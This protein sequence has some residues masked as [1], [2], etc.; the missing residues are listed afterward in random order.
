MSA[1]VSARSLAMLAAALLAA[2]PL[3]A[4]QGA[5][6]GPELTAEA[7]DAVLALYNRATTVRLHGES[8]L[9]AGTELA[10]DLGVLDGPLVIAG[11]VRGSVVVINGD[12]RLEPG[13]EIG[14]DVIVVGGIAHGLADA[15]VHGTAIVYRE[16]LRYRREGDLLVQAPLPEKASGLSA[17]H[18]FRFGR[19]DLT[20]A[21]RGAYNR[22]E[23]LPIAGGARIELG[24]SNPTLFEA[25]GIY[26]TESGLRVRDR[27]LGYALR[28]EQHVGGRRAVRLGLAL[29]SEVVPIEAHGLSDR[30]S[31]LAAFVLHRDFRDYYE[32]S[33]RAA[34][35]RIAPRGKPLNAVLELRDETHT[36]M[37][38]GK[39]WSLFDNGR[40]W[41]AQPVVAEGGLTSIAAAVT[42]D[43]RNEV[44]EPSAGWYITA[45][46]E[47]GI[48]GD[49][50][51][52]V[53]MDSATGQPVLARRA[54]DH[55]FHTALFDVRRYART[56]PGSRLAIRTLVAGSLDGGPLPPQRQHAL[57]GEGSLPGYRP[58]QFDCGARRSRLGIVEDD[59]LVETAFYPYY[60]C[61]RIAL[62]QLEYQ[63]RLPLPHDLG[64]RVSGVD[65][66]P[67]P[68]WVIFFDAGR[69]WNEAD[70]R[71]GRGAG[72]D[73]FSADAG[74]GLR[75]GRLGLYWAV[76]L[77]GGS[78]GM[79]FFVRV[80]PRL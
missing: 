41:R 33:G 2:A 18:D 66:G 62:I 59:I 80:G 7:A 65:L 11:R 10:G 36:S 20:L 17:G 69:A 5:D 3:A 24:R 39:P 46:I 56:G 6:A 70:A 75:L 21:V 13:A 45:E 67:P 77:S 1:H 16:P 29:R 27:D 8:I 55:R 40:E 49:L 74:F 32:R 53:A 42:Y 43:T 52:R 31:S 51:S 50:V 61:D 9:P 37:P 12:L 60:G 15:R 38:A 78:E 79:N 14:G 63:V 19:T 73:D 4:Q 34:Y 48:G 68:S 71:N 22:V 35:L 23:G 25:V 47:S 30:E 44:L 58:F 28:V 26:R 57:G 64:R 76:P 54:A 72:Q